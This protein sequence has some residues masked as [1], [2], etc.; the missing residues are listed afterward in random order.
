MDPRR[1]GLRGRLQLFLPRDPRPFA[2]PKGLRALFPHLRNRAGAGGGG[3]FPDLADAGPLRCAARA[4]ERPA[5]L[6]SPDLVLHFGR[7]PWRGHGLHDCRPAV[8]RFCGNSRT[9][10]RIHDHGVPVRLRP[11]VVAADHAKRYRARPGPVRCGHV[12]RSDHP[13]GPA[14]RQRDHPV[15]GGQRRQVPLRLGVLRPAFGRLLLDCR[16]APRA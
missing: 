14:Y 6:R 13:D 5:A 7:Y 10:S 4:R 1:Q 9:E 11:D 8:L 12:Y 16:L 3:R 2:G 15:V